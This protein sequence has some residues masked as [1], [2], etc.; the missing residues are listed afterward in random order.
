MKLNLVKFQIPTNWT[1]NEHGKVYLRV[2]FNG[3]DFQK[4]QPLTINNKTYQVEVLRLSVSRYGYLTVETFGQQEPFTESAEKQLLTKLAPLLPPLN[5][6]ARDEWLENY[7]DRR[8][9]FLVQQMEF[10]MRSYEED[11]KRNYNDLPRSFHV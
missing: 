4:P 6:P 3:S 1:Y 8:R 10:K 7:L 5:P 11:Y 9:E 2:S